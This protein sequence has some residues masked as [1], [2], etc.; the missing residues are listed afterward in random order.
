M[1][2]AWRTGAVDTSESIGMG[3]IYA[4]R[5]ARGGPFGG[6]VVVSPADING[7]APAS[8]AAPAACW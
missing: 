7:R 3:P 6:S 2:L 8:P 1:T 4:A 5:S